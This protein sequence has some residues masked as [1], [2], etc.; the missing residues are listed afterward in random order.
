M[1]RPRSRVRYGSLLSMAPATRPA[2][3]P[4]SR[5][6]PSVD[7]WMA[8]EMFVSPHI[9]ERRRGFALLVGSEIARRSPL[10]QHL[11]T[12]RVDESDVAL[13]AHIIQAVADYFE[14]RGREFRYPPE[15]RAAVAGHL[16][17]YDRAQV[18]A[19]LETHRLPEDGAINLGLES[20][21]CLL[22]RVPNASLHLTRLAGDKTV[23]IELRCAAV[24]LIGRVGFT[25]AVATLEGLE[26]R[27]EGRRAGQLTMLFAP[28]D[29]PDEAALLPAI[30]EALQ[31]LKEND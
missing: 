9:E 27:I 1:P 28:P 2:P 31:Q 4:A 15:I 5:A 10:T 21:S 6:V 14:V 16:R 20:L 7:P 23:G 18:L 17:K 29:H 19:L 22:E 30:K 24:E 3:R 13:R 12:S 26:A 25:D 11:L 8:G